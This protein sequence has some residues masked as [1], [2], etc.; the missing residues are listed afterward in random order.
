MTEFFLWL[1]DTIQYSFNLLR[2]VEN[3]PN[4]TFIVIGIIFFFYW[5]V[6]LYKYKKNDILE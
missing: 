4:Y 2:A 5:M 3:I 1:A 6:E